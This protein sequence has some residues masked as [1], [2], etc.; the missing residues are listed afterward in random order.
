MAGPDNAAIAERLETLACAAR[1]RRI[2]PLQRARLPARRG[3]R[4]APRRRRSPSSSAAAGRVSCAGS[5]RR[6]RPACA[7]SSRPGGLAR[8]RRARSR[9]AAGARRPRQARRPR[10]RKRMVDLG[11]ALGVRTA[12][13]L[14]EAAAE[15]RLR[16]VPGIGPQ[17]EAKI[18]QALD[19]PQ[20][21]PRRGLLLNRARAARR[22]DRRRARRPGGRRSA[23][24]QRLLG[25][26]GRRRRGVQTRTRCSTAS[27]RCRRSSRSSTGR[28]GAQSA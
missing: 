3:A 18:R 11:R 16:E 1:P 17:T 19:R 28:S 2:E 20:P 12:A 14:R 6:S 24:L 8:D 23:S 27:P 9:G 22:R 7:S 25:A 26:A 10:A 21:S 15:G 5:A 13:E 4:S